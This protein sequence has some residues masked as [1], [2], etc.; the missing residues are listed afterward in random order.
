M[1]YALLSFSIITRSSS[2]SAGANLI[3]KGKEPKFIWSNIS[4][5]PYITGSWLPIDGFGQN[6]TAKVTTVR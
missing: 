2:S 1:P 6:G 5:L 4:P 3:K